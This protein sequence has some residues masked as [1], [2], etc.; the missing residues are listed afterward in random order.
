MVGRLSILISSFIPSLA[1]A[2]GV[3]GA[4]L[5]VVVPQ[6]HATAIPEPSL[7]ALLAVGGVAVGAVKFMRRNK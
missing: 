6:A 5:D 7:L 4:V 2:D 3:A 1:M